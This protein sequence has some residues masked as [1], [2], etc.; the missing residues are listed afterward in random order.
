MTLIFWQRCK[1]R[2]FSLNSYQKRPGANIFDRIIVFSKKQ[3]S[4][5][6]K[7]T[8]KSKV[9]ITLIFLVDSSSKYGKHFPPSPLSL[10][11]TKIPNIIDLLSRTASRRESLT[12]LCSEQSVGR[13]DMSRDPYI[14]MSTNFGNNYNKH[15]SVRRGQP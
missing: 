4:S 2:Q 9:W 3:T 7:A 10:H 13:L 12:L 6:K 14:R 11:P 1:I 8:K 5:P 15:Q